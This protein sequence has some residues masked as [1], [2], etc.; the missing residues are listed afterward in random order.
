VISPSSLLFY[1]G[2]EFPDW[3]GDAFIGGLSSQSLVRIEFGGGGSNGT[4]GTA[5]E[6]ARYA[7][8]A[9]IR[10]VEQGPDG[11]IWVLEE[12]S[13]LLKLTAR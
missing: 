6:A 7:M 1:S 8:R 10:A 4:P 11:A 13:R 2:S 9:R 3:Q 5:R 12:G